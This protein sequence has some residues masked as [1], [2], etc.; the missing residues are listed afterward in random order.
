[1][2]D[3]WV[4]PPGLED[5]EKE[6]VTHSSMLA[7]EIPWTEELG[8]LQTMGVTKELDTTL[9]T[10]QLGGSQVSSCRQKKSPQVKNGRCSE[11]AV[12]HV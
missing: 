4:P 10:E 8:G 6:V 5:L 9:A 1:M 7:W 11:R 2:Q 12:F 3:T